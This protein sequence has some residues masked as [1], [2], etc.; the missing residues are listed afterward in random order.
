MRGFDLLL[1]PSSAEGLGTALI[2]AMA[3]GVPPIAFA[4]GGIPELVV[5]GEVGVLV[6]ADDVKGFARAVERL[7]T[8]PSERRLLGSRGPSRAALFAVDRMI[9][10]TRDV[11][12]TVLSQHASSTA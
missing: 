5:D 4:V 12:A 3:L 1:H 9:G 7:V 10:G 2:D 8:Q 6:P 11:Y